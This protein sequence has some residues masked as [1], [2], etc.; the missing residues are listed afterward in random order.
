MLAGFFPIFLVGLVRGCS[1]NLYF[2]S[3]VVPIEV[4]S[5]SIKVKRTVAGEEGSFCWEDLTKCSWLVLRFLLNPKKLMGALSKPTF[6]SSDIWLTMLIPAWIVS[7]N[8]Y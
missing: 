3:L 1:S 2:S 5:F 7:G 4:G 8:L 6:R